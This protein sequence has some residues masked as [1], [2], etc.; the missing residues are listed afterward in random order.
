MGKPDYDYVETVLKP[1]CNLYGMAIG[2]DETC[3]VVIWG[4][5]SDEMKYKHQRRAKALVFPSIRE[6][7]GLIISEAAVLGTP[8]ITYDAPGTRD[9]VDHGKA[10]YMTNFNGID[11]IVDCMRDLLDNQLK[12]EKIRKEAWD[13]SHKLDFNVTAELF[14]DALKHW[15]VE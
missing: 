9:A 10:G 15:L 14:Y 4:F 5:V 12:Y 7:W 13:Y 8:S 11:G 3:D 6:G 1:I 2:E